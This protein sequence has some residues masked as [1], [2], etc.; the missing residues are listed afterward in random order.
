MAEKAKKDSA[1]ANES[2]TTNPRPQLLRVSTIINKYRIDSVTANAVMS[3]NR[4]K[5]SS[6]LETA[7]FLKMV[8]SFRKRKIKISGGI[9]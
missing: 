8:E 1:A 4:L 3:A 9:R 5:L 7:K 2:V 6:R